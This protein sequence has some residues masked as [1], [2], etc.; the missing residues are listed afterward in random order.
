MKHAGDFW[1]R[2]NDSQSKDD[3]SVSVAPI[4]LPDRLAMRGILSF[5]IVVLLAVGLPARAQRGDHKGKE[6]PEV[7]RTMKVPPAPTLTPA[8]ALKSFKLAPGFRIEI[9]AADPLIHDPVA[10]DLRC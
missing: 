8:Q 4:K 2:G 10:M 9:A 3:L 5:S 6:Q 1:P 7:W